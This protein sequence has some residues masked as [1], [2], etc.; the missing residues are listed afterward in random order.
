MLIKNFRFEPEGL[1]VQSPDFLCRSDFM[2]KAGLRSVEPKVRF[3]LKG[4]F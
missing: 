1:F 2:C 3:D 4:K